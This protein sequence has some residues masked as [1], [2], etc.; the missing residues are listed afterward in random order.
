MHWATHESTPRAGDWLLRR[1]L[2]SQ[3]SRASY[4]SSTAA[5]GAFSTTPRPLGA[6]GEYVSTRTYPRAADQKVPRQFIP[7]SW[8]PMWGVDGRK[9]QRADL[10]LQEGSPAVNPGQ[11]LPAEWPD[12][13]READKDAPDIG[14]LPLRAAPWGVG[15][16]G[17]ISIFGDPG[18]PTPP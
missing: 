5:C 17:R 6:A 14:A 3:L 16:D 18:T 15:V 2:P 10:R 13:L 9:S 11:P 1:R 4:R 7:A 12:P 8:E